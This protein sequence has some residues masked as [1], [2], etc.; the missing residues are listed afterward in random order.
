M[1][2]GT[3]P[4]PVDYDLSSSPAGG[5]ET[6]GLLFTSYTRLSCVRGN[7][8]GT[9]QAAFSILEHTHEQFLGS[10]FRARELREELEQLLARADEVVLDFTGMKSI[11]QSFVDELVG[12]LVLQHGPDVVQR[13]VFRSCSEDIK[14]ILSFVVS[15]RSEDFLRKNKH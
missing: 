2:L 3:G 7:P 4:V 8:G 6:F 10:R 12:V 11:T 13:L 1:N 9:M 14:E 5:N 15:S